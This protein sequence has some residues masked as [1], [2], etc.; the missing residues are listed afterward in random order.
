MINFEDDAV[1]E[2][3]HAHGWRQLP[4]DVVVIEADMLR[5]LV[6]QLPTESDLI[7]IKATISEFDGEDNGESS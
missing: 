4:D 1:I 7:N 6:M 2:E 5:R 3:L